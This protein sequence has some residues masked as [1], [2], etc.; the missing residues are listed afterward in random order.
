MQGQDC[1]FGVLA[2][3]AL[4]CACGCEKVIKSIAYPSY[5]DA[6]EMSERELEAIAKHGNDM[7]KQHE[8]M[9]P[10]AAEAIRASKAEFDEAI[11][12][13]QKEAEEQRGTVV[14]L[15]ANV[16]SVV[17]KLGGFPEFEVIENLFEN[18][19]ADARE[20]KEE[21][22]KVGEETRDLGETTSKLGAKLG[23]VEKTLAKLDPSTI[24]KLEFVSEET[25]RALEGLKDEDR[26]FREKL[27]SELQLYNAEMA[28]L[29]GISVEEILALLVAAGSAA[30]AGGALGKTGKS[31]GHVEIEKLK[32]RIDTITTDIALAKPSSVAETL[33]SHGSKRG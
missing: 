13:L 27:Q 20:A 24:A 9:G 7:A 21:R 25:M 31:R 6:Q 3:L 8:A 2:A 14:G 4:L 1:L 32:D 26:A 22:K 12:R 16:G 29:T 10:E 30:A 19:D 18:V 23:A 11:F 17:A 5:L 15:V 28:G 33:V